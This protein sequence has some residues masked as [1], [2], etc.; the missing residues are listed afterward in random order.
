MG[1]RNNIKN[2]KQIFIQIK[3]RCGEFF[4]VFFCFFFKIVIFFFF[5]SLKI[6][7]SFIYMSV[8]KESKTNGPPRPVNQC[9]CQTP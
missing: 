1:T 3:T 2:Q 4:C 8:R 7:M 5:L 6:S 9:H